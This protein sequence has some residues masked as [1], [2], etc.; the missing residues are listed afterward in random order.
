VRIAEDTE[1]AEEA[2]KGDRILTV[3]DDT[4]PLVSPS[5]GRTIQKGLKNET[6]EKAREE[7]WAKTH[8]LGVLTI[9]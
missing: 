2:I 6:K 3:E 5:L 1:D 7:F 4:D 9:V 8:L